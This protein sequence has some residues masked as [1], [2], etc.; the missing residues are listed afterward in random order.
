MEKSLLLRK[1]IYFV[2]VGLMLFPLV[3]L[4]FYVPLNTA[5][6]DP[7]LLTVIMGSIL[8]TTISLIMTVFF[9]VVGSFGLI[10][11]S[12]R[13]KPFCFDGIIL[14]ILAPCFIPPLLV[15]VLIAKSSGS[16]PIGLGAVVFYHT[17]TNA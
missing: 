15:V 7:F 13:V 8:Q 3:H 10:W 11:L 1:A 17:F 12:G 5:L 6:W 16:F 14:A 4:F 2:V 9:G